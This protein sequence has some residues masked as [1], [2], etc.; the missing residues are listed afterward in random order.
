MVHANGSASSRLPPIILHRQLLGVPANNITVF[1]T[2]CSSD[3]SAGSSSYSLCAVWIRQW[4]EGHSYVFS[5]WISRYIWPIPCDQF[6]SRSNYT[7]NHTSA[8][9]SSPPPL[10]RNSTRIGAPQYSSELLSLDWTSSISFHSQ[11]LLSALLYPIPHTRPPLSVLLSPRWELFNSHR[12]S[13]NAFHTHYPTPF[14][15]SSSGISTPQSHRCSA[16]P[17]LA[18]LYFILHSLTHTPTPS[19]FGAPQFHSAL[20][21]P[22][23]FIAPQL[24]LDALLYHSALLQHLLWYSSFP[25]NTPHLVLLLSPGSCSHFSSECIILPLIPRFRFAASSHHITPVLD[26]TNWAKRHWNS[27]LSTCQERIISKYK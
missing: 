21:N 14:Q 13:Y 27:I 25:H 7:I 11:F 6:S 24:K 26:I 16:L 9:A 12:R 5:R 18:L 1:P 17:G 19:S 20:L 3:F 8:A 22:S 15:C 4:E 23:S 2:S 10:W